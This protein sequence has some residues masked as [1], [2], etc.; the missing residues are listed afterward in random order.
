MAP[1]VFDINLPAIDDAELERNVE[2]KVQEFV[3]HLE[4]QGG[5]KGQIAVMFHE[6]RP[7]KNS[8]WFTAKAE[9][10]VCWERWAVTISVVYRTEVDQ[11]NIRKKVV[12]TLSNCLLEIIRYVNEKK[13]HIPPITKPDA[14]PYQIVI[15]SSNDS[16]ISLF[17]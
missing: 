4:S 6:K 11:R 1:E 12:E 3:K 10:E 13:D 5:Q 14:F 7:K 8:S 15:P 16:W 17:K 2:E 9:E